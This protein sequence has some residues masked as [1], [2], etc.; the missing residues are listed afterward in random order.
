MVEYSYNNT[1]LGNKKELKTCAHSNTGEACLCWG[2]ETKNKRQYSALF[3]LYR[4]L[5]L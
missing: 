2:K 4:I 5:E 1:L 3:Y